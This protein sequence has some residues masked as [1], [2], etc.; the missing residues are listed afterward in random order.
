MNSEAQK[1]YVNTKY[2]TSAHVLNKSEIEI[3]APSDTL[4]YIGNTW[5]WLADVYT[6]CGA[7]YAINQSG[8]ISASQH[9]FSIRPV[10]ELKADIKTSGKG[11]DEFGQEAWRLIP[12]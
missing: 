8:S 11:L 1:Q 7:L 12:Q 5:Y 6:C 4:R 3:F 10:V 9:T 2:A